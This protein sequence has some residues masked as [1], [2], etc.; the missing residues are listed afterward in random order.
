MET[1]KIKVFD[2]YSNPSYYSVM[3]QSI[4][5]ALEFA[6][7]NNEEFVEVNKFEFDKMI[8]DYNEKMKVIS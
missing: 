8:N 2:Y 6:S 3:P 7:I 5:D 4:F 1:I